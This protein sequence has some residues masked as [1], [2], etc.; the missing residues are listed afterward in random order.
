MRGLPLS[1]HLVIIAVA[2]TLA[3]VAAAL[4]RRH[5]VTY[6]M[7]LGILSVV[8]PLHFVW[9][10]WPRGVAA[11]TESTTAA[12]ARDR[13]VFI[14]VFDEI[15]LEILLDR[16]GVIDRDAFPN[17]HRFAGE[18]VW[19]RQAIVNYP[20]TRLSIPSALTGSFVPHANRGGFESI[21]D[22]PAPNLLSL[23]ARDGYRVSFYSSVFGCR[24]GVF[25]CV[26]YFDGSHLETVWR[27]VNGT[28]RVY[29]PAALSVRLVPGV[30]AYRK[31]AEG[32]L[33][34]DLADSRFSRPGE[35]SLFHL[36]I[37]H[38]PFVLSRDGVPVAS[39]DYDLTRFARLEPTLER[40]REQIRY[41]DRQFGR[42]LA[43]LKASGAWDRSVI[44]VTSDHGT[45]WKRGC[46]GRLGIEAV[47]PALA[48]VPMMIRASFLAPRIV[49]ED[50]QHIDFR[51]TLLDVLDIGEPGDAATTGRSALGRALPPRLRRFVIGEHVLDL[52]YP[53]RRVELPPSGPGA[54]EEP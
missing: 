27:I 14:F 17:L 7:F 31:I 42:F 18:S 47:E 22:V 30:W 45:C 1:T 3:L 36:L 41:L 19:F 5:L 35:A 25:T 32:R 11:A 39:R 8:L 29:I 2:A 50:Y 15:S 53:A 13:T 49:D 26:R 28:A 52:G 20:Y 4:S 48:R 6:A 46:T 51:A 23:L 10:A 9:A 34:E 37:T 12:T 33:L 38:S 40:Y 43:R 44:V 24:S 54:A 16:G 21:T